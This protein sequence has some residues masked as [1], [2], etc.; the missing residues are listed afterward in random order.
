MGQVVGG[1]GADVGGAGGRAVVEGLFR[2]EGFDKGVVVWGAGGDDFAAGARKAT[3]QYGTES[4]NEIAGQSLKRW[5]VTHS[6]A[7]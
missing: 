7:Y 6:F 4:Y 5:D 3:C 2:A 1:V